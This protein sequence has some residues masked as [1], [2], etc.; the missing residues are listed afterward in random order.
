MLILIID[1]ERVVLSDECTKLLALGYADAVC[2]EG[3]LPDL[4]PVVAPAR[5]GKFAEPTR[6]ENF[7]DD[8][9]V[10]AVG[11]QFFAALLDGPIVP[12]PV[13]LPPST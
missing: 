12:G 6:L 5:P 9:R 11:R 1:G 13:P 7:T 8:P 10:V 4:P 2:L 3:A